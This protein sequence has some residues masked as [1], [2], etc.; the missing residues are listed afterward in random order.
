VNLS[1]AREI[2]QASKVT[3]G[4][5][6]GKTRFAEGFLDCYNQLAPVIDALEKIV[7]GKHKPIDKT[8]DCTIGEC[9][10]FFR[11]AKDALETV[12]KVRG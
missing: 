8:E 1:G 11:C 7:K 2:V 4:G 10:C 12:K 5:D 6:Y 3:K 9:D